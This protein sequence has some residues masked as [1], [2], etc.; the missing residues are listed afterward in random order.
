MI[1]AGAVIIR[2]VT[3]GSETKIGAN[4]AVINNIPG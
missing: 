2:N 3:I 4:A 1:G